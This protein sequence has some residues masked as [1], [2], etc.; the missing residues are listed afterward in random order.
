M[1]GDT[2][3]GYWR[4]ISPVGRK[5]ITR[6]FQ[7]YGGVKPPPINHQGIHDAF[8]GKASVVL[9]FYRGKWLKL[10]GAD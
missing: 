1:K 6:D 9:Y 3:I 7:A 4:E 8:I 10:T 5:V 2:K